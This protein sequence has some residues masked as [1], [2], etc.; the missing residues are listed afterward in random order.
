L[1]ADKNQVVIAISRKA[2]INSLRQFLND[3]SEQLEA[4]FSKLY[5][6]TPSI[7]ERDLRI[8]EIRKT[9]KMTFDEIADRIVNEFKL[10][11]K[12]AEMNCDSARIAYQRARK[13][14]AELFSPRNRT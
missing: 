12:D 6:E 10:D 11:D 7:S 2:S 8:Y 3:N 1:E 4:M 14:I 13:R 9:T 5:H